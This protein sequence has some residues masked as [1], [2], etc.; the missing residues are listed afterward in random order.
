[1]VVRFV[2]DTH[3]DVPVAADD[4]SDLPDADVVQCVV[5]VFKRV[6]FPAPGGGH[7]VTVRYPFVF[8][9]SP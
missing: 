2:I 6:S 8:H 9:P 4:G 1:M 5:S 3:G 7:I